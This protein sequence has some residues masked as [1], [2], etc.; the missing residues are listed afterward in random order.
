MMAQKPRDIEF[1]WAEKT[2][3]M[4][5]PMKNIWAAKTTE[6]RKGVIAC[7]PLARL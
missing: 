4:T 5:I 2:A 7:F 1:P 3:Q 6:G